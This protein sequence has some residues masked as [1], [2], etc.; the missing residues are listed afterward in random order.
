MR[1]TLSFA[2]PADWRNEKSRQNY[3]KH[4]QNKDENALP[5]IFLAH[6]RRELQ[7]RTNRHLLSRKLFS[8]FVIGTVDVLMG[9]VSLLAS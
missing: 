1:G 7:S 4:R 2:F 6:P 5:I 8:E 3:T 9:A